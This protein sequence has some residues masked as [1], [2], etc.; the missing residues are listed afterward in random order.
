MCYNNV[1]NVS[2]PC[3]PVFRSWIYY[4]KS[5]DITFKFLTRCNLPVWEPPQHIDDGGGGDDDDGGDGRG[6][7]GDDDDDDD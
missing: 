1:T 7:G 2:K 6:G 5:A 3:I 4:S